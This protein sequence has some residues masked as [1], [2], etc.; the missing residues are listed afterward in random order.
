MSG[1]NKRVNDRYAAP[2]EAVLQILRQQHSA[3]CRNGGTEDDGVPNAQAMICSEIDGDF[4]DFLRRRN[5]RESIAPPEACV[6]RLRK[7]RRRLAHEN[8]EELGE[9]LRR[10]DDSAA[11]DS[12]DQFQRNVAPRG[13]VDALGIQ[14]D[15]RVERDFQR[16]VVVEFVSGPRLGIHDRLGTQS[17]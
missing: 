7:R 9:R 6:P 8:I 13:V 11:G 15:I 17:C 1:F 3:I 2:R 10:D 14:K 12:F 5:D 16:S 4:D